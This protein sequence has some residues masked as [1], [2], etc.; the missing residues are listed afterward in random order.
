MMG[1]KTAVKVAVSLP[2]DLLA[3]ADRAAQGAHLSRSG[4]FREALAAYLR[5]T[6][7]SDVQRY[8]AAYREYPE[9]AEEVE[10]ALA[11]ACELL[12]AAPYEPYA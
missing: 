2:P 12:V 10:A 11:S 1:M 7:V 6:E 4:Y 9:G 3:A 5:E 8:I